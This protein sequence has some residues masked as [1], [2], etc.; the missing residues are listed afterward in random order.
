M[1]TLHC[2]VLYLCSLRLILTQL[3]ITRELNL[4]IRKLLFKK[5]KLYF[6]KYIVWWCRIDL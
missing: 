1:D 3:D 4:K 6:W 5:S 2:K